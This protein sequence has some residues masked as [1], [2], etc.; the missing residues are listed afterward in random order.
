MPRKRR[1]AVEDQKAPS[2]QAKSRRK[3]K[4]VFTRYVRLSQKQE[5]EDLPQQSTEGNLV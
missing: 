3:E 2:S 5:K 1:G 4:P